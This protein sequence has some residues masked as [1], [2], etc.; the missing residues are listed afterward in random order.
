MQSYCSEQVSYNMEATTC[1]DDTHMLSAA[2]F[3]EMMKPSRAPRAPTVHFDHVLLASELKFLAVLKKPG[4]FSWTGEDYA[5][6]GRS[7]SPNQD[8]LAAH[9]SVLK[10]ILKHAGT[11]FPAQA[12]M[13]RAMVRLHN[14]HQIFGPDL[15]AYRVDKV[16]STSS[17]HWRIMCKHVYELRK[18]TAE[19]ED[20]GLQECLDA[21]DLSWMPAPESPP[22]PS[23]ASATP[24]APTRQASGVQREH[25]NKTLK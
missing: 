10:I 9:S 24:P 21:I 11:G 12:C 8:S 13:N 6:L 16:C 4:S 20:P 3:F 19:C 15:P 17:D 23:A 25:F 18:K 7:L 1:K 5:A 22:A 2:I 14:Q